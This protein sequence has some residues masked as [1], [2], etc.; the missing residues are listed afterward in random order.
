M[1]EINS[2]EQADE[3]RRVNGASTD[4]HEQG[5]QKPALVINLYSWITPIV[6]LVMLVLG[7]LAG[8]Y[9]RPLIT[10]DT[11]S[12]SSSTAN[13]D[14]QSSSSIQPAPTQAQPSQEDVKEV[15]DYLVR[16]TRHLKGDPDA[17][18]TLIEFSDFQ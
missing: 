2:Q 15:M 13:Q 1:V 3:P 12:P 16:E 5:V 11:A 8:Y 14:S 9:A 18:I 6:G 10:G 7:L 4:S 17:P